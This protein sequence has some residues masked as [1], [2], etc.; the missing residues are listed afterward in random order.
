MKNI[1]IDL[2]IKEAI[3]NYYCAENRF[4]KTYWLG[5]VDALR[6]IKK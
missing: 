5:F 2:V 3:E 1:D 6:Y 4:R